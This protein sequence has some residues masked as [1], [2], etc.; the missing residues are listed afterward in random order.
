MFRAACVIYLPFGFSN[1]LLCH[2]RS[3]LVSFWNLLF[4]PLPF[5]WMDAWQRSDVIDLV[6]SKKKRI[7][8]S[9]FKK[10]HPSKF[11]S[12]N[13]QGVRYA[14]MFLFEMT[15]FVNLTLYRNLKWQSV[16]VDFSV[17]PPWPTAAPSTLPNFG[18][19]HCLVQNLKLTSL[20][21]TY[22]GKVHW[23]CRHFFS[24]FFLLLLRITFI[25]LHTWELPGK[26]SVF[27]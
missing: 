8:E 7:S 12:R 13:N 25:L 4:L 11:W 24:F 16:C 23:A 20:N 18:F 26:T 3:Q 10:G 21:F 17:G 14:L 15:P 27:N 1:S 19:A 2:Y 9:N 22:P 5:E 6:K